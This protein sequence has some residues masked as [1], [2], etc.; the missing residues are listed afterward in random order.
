MKS[1][2]SGKTILTEGKSKIVFVEPKSKSA[3]YCQILNNYFIPM[4]HANCVEDFYLIKDNA[5][6]H[7]I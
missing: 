2:I 5:P 3:E 4:A 1:Q 7:K 6:I